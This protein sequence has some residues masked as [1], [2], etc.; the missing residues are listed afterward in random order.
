MVYTFSHSGHVSGT[1]SSGSRDDDWGNNG[2]NQ[3]IK[4][5]CVVVRRVMKRLLT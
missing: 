3:Q 4:V 2:F 5:S 1:F